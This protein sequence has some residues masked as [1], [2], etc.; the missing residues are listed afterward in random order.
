MRGQPF[1]LFD[2][3]ADDPRT[4]DSYKKLLS[5]ERFPFWVVSRKGFFLLSAYN[6]KAFFGVKRS[7]FLVARSAFVC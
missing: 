6:L 5:A 2:V 4:L 7:A 3:E 1:L